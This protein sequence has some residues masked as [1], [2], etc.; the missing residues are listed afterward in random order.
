M[1]NTNVITYNPDQTDYY[2]S[3]LN[4]KLH[5]IRKLNAMNSEFLSG[6]WDTNIKYRSSFDKSLMELQPKYYQERDK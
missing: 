4:N 5:Q 2:S 3:I 6:I 1:D